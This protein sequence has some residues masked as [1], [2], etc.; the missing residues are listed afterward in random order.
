M[1]CASLKKISL[2]HGDLLI[3][4]LLDH[5]VMKPQKEG[6][7]LTHDSYSRRYVGRRAALPLPDSGASHVLLRD[8][9]HHPES[10]RSTSPQTS[11]ADRRVRVRR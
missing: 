11:T 2:C 7:Q 6:M 4:Q 8:R 10:R 1:R 5:F 9:D 3:T